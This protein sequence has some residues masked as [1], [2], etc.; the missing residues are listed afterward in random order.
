MINKNPTSLL[1]F[2][3]GSGLGG[4]IVRWA[5]WSPFAHVGFRLVDGTVLDATPT[6]GVSIR[7]PTDNETTEYW[8]V[9]APPSVMLDAVEWAKTQIGK[10]YDL[11]GIVGFAFRRGVPTARDWRDHRSWFCS[12][13]V[14]EA[15]NI[16]GCPLLQ[17]NG[18]YN[19]ITPRDLLLSNR[20]RKTSI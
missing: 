5:S 1:R 2:S 16:A 18:C 9:D 19:R 12:E 14:C 20:L 6:Y 7:K 8:E 17:D 10:P 13:L 11:G 4:A 15:F 3:A